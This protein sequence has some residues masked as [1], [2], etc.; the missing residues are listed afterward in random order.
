MAVGDVTSS[1]SLS[2]FCE[3]SSRYD[4]AET[5]RAVATTR[6]V[7]CLAS[8]VANPAPIPDEQPVTVRVNVNYCAE[9]VMLVK[10]SDPVSGRA[11]KSRFG[12]RRKENVVIYSLSQTASCGSVYKSLFSI[13]TKSL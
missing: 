8:R 5:C 7:V 3:S 4:S 1:A 9:L 2:T 13:V 12:Q 6:F 11:S 10:N